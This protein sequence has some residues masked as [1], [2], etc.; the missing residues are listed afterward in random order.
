MEIR[1][2]LGGENVSEGGRSTS[3]RADDED[4][5]LC[6]ACHECSCV[7]GDFGIVYLGVEEGSGFILIMVCLRVLLKCFQ[8]V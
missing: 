6:S 2:L 3:P 4:V 7:R 1:V 5:L 8:L